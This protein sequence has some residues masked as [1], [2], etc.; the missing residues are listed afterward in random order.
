MRIPPINFINEC[1][2]KLIQPP[3]PKGTNSLL[4][5]FYNNYKKYIPKYKLIKNTIK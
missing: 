4:S 1:T 3:A 5:H 2:I